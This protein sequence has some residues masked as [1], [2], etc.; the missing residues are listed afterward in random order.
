MPLKI[1]YIIGSTSTQSIN[2]KLADAVIRLADD[3]VEFT[4]IPIDN[5]PLYNYDLDG[6]YPP[7]AVTLKNAIRACD[8][9]LFATPEYNRSIPGALKNA[10]DWASRPYGRN[11]VANIPS[12][13]IGASIGAPGTAMAQQHLRNVLAY[14]DSPALQQPEAFIFYTTERFAADGTVTDESTRE[15]LQTWMD[16]F[17]AWVRHFATS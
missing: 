7:V 5:L 11:A 3:D 2:R 14:L 15:F 16:A 9:L 8:G 6:D 1:G 12:G 17:L 4:E 10:L 13:I